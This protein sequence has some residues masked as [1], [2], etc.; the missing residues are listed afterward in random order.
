M[1]FPFFIVGA[2]RS[3]TTLL[4]M[5][6]NAHS[7]I[8]VPEEARFLMPLLTRRHL[9]GGLDS[10]ALGRLA[11]YLAAS[12]EYA[13]WN[14]ASAAFLE[15]IR[16]QG[17][18]DL[19]E[20]VRMLYTSYAASEGKPY[21]GDKSLFFQRI[22]L[23]HRLFPQAAFIHIVR[24]GRDVFDS[25]RKMDAAK[26]CAPAGALD[27][28]LKL[29]LI[30]RAFRRLPAELTM[31]VRYEDLLAEPRAAAEQ[32]CRFLGVEFEPGMLRF[33]E[34]SGQYVGGHHSQLIFKPIETTNGAKWPRNLSRREMLAFDLI[35]GP[36]LERFGY[37]RSGQTC[38]LLDR[39]ALGAE[40]LR[41][42]SA[43][44]LGMAADALERRRAL[45]EG[46]ATETIKVGE[47]PAQ[48]RGRP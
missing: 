42:A 29:G 39:A 17:H 24:D 6:L 47:R 38:T 26:N 35:A 10:A 37:G 45:R 31:T 3:G 14:Y 25:W 41:G 21:W 12:K 33:H 44:A 22:G 15:A 19:A 48:R 2:Q 11:D 7:R 34:A 27:W 4:R 1:G 30:E 18:L 23:L 28:R 8:A 43:R 13:N 32:V 5:I 9:Q 16:V 40:L 20:F 46:R 36:W